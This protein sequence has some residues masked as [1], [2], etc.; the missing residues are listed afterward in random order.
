MIVKASREQ[1]TL[2]VRL[3][4][5]RVRW[6]VYHWSL[7][8]P[9]NAKHAVL[10]EFLYGSWWIC[11]TDHGYRVRSGR[12]RTMPHLHDDAVIVLPITIES[13]FAFDWKERERV[14]PRDGF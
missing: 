7:R 4:G 8:L 12:K 11:R 10:E 2:S 6:K 1:L 5:I 13:H 14:S 3:Y 9:R